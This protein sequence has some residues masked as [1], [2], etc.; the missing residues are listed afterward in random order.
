MP[1]QMAD[2]SHTRADELL[3][4]FHPTLQMQGPKAYHQYTLCRYGKSFMC[5]ST[6]K[7]SHDRKLFGGEKILSWL[8]VWW[9]WQPADLDVEKPLLMV[10]NKGNTL[11]LE[12]Q[13]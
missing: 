5:L 2:A 10:Y 9:F 13:H 11:N 1:R 4:S 6:S 12:E 7:K 3:L 8:Q